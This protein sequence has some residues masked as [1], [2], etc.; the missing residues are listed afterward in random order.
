LAAVAAVAAV[1]IASIAELTF[2]TTSSLALK[3]HAAAL[4]PA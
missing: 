1:A 3:T 4:K 2:D